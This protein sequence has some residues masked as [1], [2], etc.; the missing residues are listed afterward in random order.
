MIELLL[1]VVFC[2]NEEEEG[3]SEDKDITLLKIS[4]KVLLCP[5]NSL[6]LFKELFV[7]LNSISFDII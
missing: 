1:I 5:T 4:E 3:D 2:I 7:L 6:L